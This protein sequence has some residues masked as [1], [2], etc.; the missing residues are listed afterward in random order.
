MRTLKNV[1]AWLAD[2]GIVRI[3]ITCQNGVI[4]AIEDVVDPQ[5]PSSFASDAVVLP[6]FIDQHIH[7]LYGC[8]AMDADAD[9]L[10]TISRELAK[11][12]TTSFLATTLTQ[13]PEEIKRALAVTCDY[14]QKNEFP[15]AAIIGVHLEGPFISQ[16][17]V[18]A[19]NPNF[20]QAPDIGRFEE[21][22]AAAGGLIRI[23]SLA[24]EVEGAEALIAHLA[25]NGVRASAGHTSATY[26]D[27]EQAI[28]NGLR[29]VTHTY[30]GQS[31]VHHREVGVAGSAML[32]DEL[33]TELICDTVHVSVP[34]LKLM[35]KNKPLDKVI[36]ITDSIR[37]K[38]LPDG[39]FDLGGQTVYLKNGEARLASGVLA[40][41][42]LRANYAIRN[43]VERVGVPFEN[44]VAF[45]TVN[46]ATHLGVYD[47]MGSIA[48]GKDASF[49]VLDER[50]EVLETIVKGKTVYHA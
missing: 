5:S 26:A 3:N 31:G 15:G 27:M 9:A 33:Y 37:P 25:K 8:E 19:Q 7:G 32:F 48:V 17:F 12:G 28:G 18:G 14:V 20:V 23:V 49:A 38:S 44:A 13:S 22:Q 2:R 47:R 43:L 11:E 50:F 24:P 35:I 36:L 4:T 29:C 16:K 1:R 21:Y 6:G 34:A 42:S 45:A 39:E 46:P 41:S 40:G 30:N 10:D